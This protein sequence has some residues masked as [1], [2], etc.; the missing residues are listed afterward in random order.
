MFARDVMSHPV[1][2]FRL[3][4]PARVAAAQL[5]SRGFVGAP[6]MTAEGVVLG[7]VTETDLLRGQVLAATSRTRPD[8]A[9][10]TTVAEV[11]SP[12]PFVIKPDDD[13]TDVVELML[14]R[15]VRSVP[16]IDDGHL[17]GIVSRRDVLRSMA[18]RE[19][20]QQGR[21]RECR[22]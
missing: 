22:P 17:V 11:M 13:L 16:I 7:I 14:T 5:V 18:R 6:V 12:A 4:T 8:P 10:D 3:H 21:G 15:S 1:L 2:T 9:P 19:L 20:M